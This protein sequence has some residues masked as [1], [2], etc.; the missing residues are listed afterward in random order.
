[1]TPEQNKAIIRRYIDELNRR[2]TAI[3][4]DLIADE[5]RSD[6][7]QGYERNTMAFPDYFVGVLDMI[8]E[9]E[10]VVVEWTFRGT[11]L[12]P[13]QG[14]PPTGKIISGT[15]ISVY[16]VVDGRIA[17]AH[18]VWDQSEIWRQLGLAGPPAEESE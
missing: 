2:N 5:F 12:G 4:D 1:M 15:A 13:Y 10:Q 6:V 16:R 7:R 9:G 14:I 8:A 17:G 3:L 18:G 11:H